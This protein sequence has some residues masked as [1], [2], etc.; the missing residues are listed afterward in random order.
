MKKYLGAIGTVVITGI[1]CKGLLVK[2]VRRVL[3]DELIKMEA[4]GSQDN[5]DEVYIF[6]TEREALDTLENMVK[7][8]EEY[9]V[10]TLSDFKSLMGD[11][12]LYTDTKYGWLELSEATISK[13]SAG[14]VLDLPKVGLL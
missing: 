8:I 4:E 5:T 3:K 7:L 1:I 2:V 9:K 14:Y 6:D 10:V 12:S 13:I 11:N